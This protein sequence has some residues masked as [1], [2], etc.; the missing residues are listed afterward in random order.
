[1]AYQI[2]FNS[3]RNNRGRNNQNPEQIFQSE[4]NTMKPLPVIP[5]I[6]VYKYIQLIAK[7]NEVGYFLP[8]PPS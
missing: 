1:F 5:P 3:F 8:L 7:D 2:W 6:L 4:L